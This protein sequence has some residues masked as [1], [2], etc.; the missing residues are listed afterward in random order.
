MKINIV[1]F[2]LVS[3]MALAGISSAAI[4][5]Q[6]T[7]S[8]STS[9]PVACALGATNKPTGCTDTVVST[10]NNNPAQQIW[11]CSQADKAMLSKT[12]ESEQIKNI[13][14]N[15][16]YIIDNFRVNGTK[17]VG[18]INIQCLTYVKRLGESFVAPICYPPSAS[19]NMSACQIPTDK[20]LEKSTITSSECS[21]G[22]LQYDEV[23][24]TLVSCK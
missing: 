5:S 11:F 8:T 21:K 17:V 19:T 13:S 18:G 23:H 14:N 2:P 12:K 16:K 20:E 4:A 10:L 15:L 24:P 6:P 9:T 7:Q 3:A 1:L 22:Y